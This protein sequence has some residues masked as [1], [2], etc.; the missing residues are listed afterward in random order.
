MTKAVTEDQLILPL[1]ILG[2]DFNLWTNFLLHIF[3]TPCAK[4]CDPYNG[5]SK[6]RHARAYVSHNLWHM[7]VN[8]FYA[9]Q[10]VF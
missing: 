6:Y 2:Y 4:D 1:C 8:S 5:V 7:L 9:A 10:A 3:Y